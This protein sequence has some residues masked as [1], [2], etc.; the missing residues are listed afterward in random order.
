MVALYAIDVGA[1][2]QGLSVAGA[3]P[4]LGEGG[5]GKD[6]LATAV[7]DDHAVVD[8][9]GGKE[10]G[11]EDASVGVAKDDG[12][13]DEGGDIVDGGHEH[14]EGVGVFVSDVAGVK[15]TD[16]VAVTLDGAA[17]VGVGVREVLRGGQRTL[18]GGDGEEGMVV[19]AAVDVVA[20]AA[21]VGVDFDAEGHGGDGFVVF[22]MGEADVGGG[23]AGG[24]KGGTG[25]GL[26][27]KRVVG[28]D[29]AE[30]D[31]NTRNGEVGDECVEL[32]GTRGTD[33]EMVKGVATKETI[34]E[35][36]V[37]HAVGHVDVAV[38]LAVEMAGAA[39]RGDFQDRIMIVGGEGAGVEAAVE[40]EDAE[41]VLVSGV[42][43]V[44]A[45]IA[46]VLAPP[47]GVEI[48]AGVAHTDVITQNVGVGAG[49][50]SEEDEAVADG[51]DT[52]AAGGCGVG[53]GI[54]DAGGV[55]TQKSVGGEGFEVVVHGVVAE[56]PVKGV[57][58]M[59]VGD[60]GDECE[61]ALVGEMAIEIEGVD[62]GDGVP[63]EVAYMTAEGH[64]TG[65]T[66][67]L[68]KGGKGEEE[69]EEEVKSGRSRKIEKSKNRA[70]YQIG[71]STNHYIFHL[72]D[73]I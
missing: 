60:G 72:K 33:G 40:S 43:C 69:Q 57:D 32:E 64:S 36:V 71:L 65:K 30:G 2:W 46:G 66:H 15:S 44:G 24:E 3:V 4:A 8:S 28:A 39:A 26:R 54:V 22:N 23:V 68:S 10:T 19:D 50:P 6:L 55:G 61:G 29:D 42:E 5:G 51:G 9:H 63:A 17:Y 35:A 56:K 49:V 62:R 20:G 47:D 14:L 1:L 48:K 21:V 31:F 11:Q 25:Q 12:V 52:E 18:L 34:G 59:G 27:K 53:V 41:A 13:G 37:G 70:F 45:E 58:I 73:C 16:E 38:P 67:R 7:V